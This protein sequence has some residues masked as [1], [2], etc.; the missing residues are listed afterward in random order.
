MWLAG[1]LLCGRIIRV[2]PPL[3]GQIAVGMLVGG[4]HGL[5]WMDDEA[6][7]FPLGILVILGEV[8]LV[9]LLYGPARVAASGNA[10][11][12]HGTARIGSVLPTITGTVL[13]YFV[14]G[15]DNFTAA[16]ALRCSFGPT[17]AGI[18]LN[19]LQPCG[20]LATPLGQLIVATAIIDDIIALV[21]LSLIQALDRE[22]R[23]RQR[24]Q[25][26][27]GK[28]RRDCRTHC[29]RLGLVVCGWRHCPLCHCPLRH[30]RNCSRGWII[31]KTRC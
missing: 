23:Q 29:L 10:G 5:G 24:Q 31:W 9:L 3:I 12:G 18:A 20:V 14:L 13:A 19:V 7:R 17:S 22:R 21:V 27:W 25:R 6:F 11:H 26:R 1:H 4:P 16:V 15:V 8:G 28:G 2:L 30:C